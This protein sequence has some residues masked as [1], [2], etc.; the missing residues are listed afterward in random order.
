MPENP[1]LAA[2][3]AQRYGPWALIAGG[4][5]GVG[6]SFARMLA[7]AGI[8]LVLLARRQSPLETL[9]H[10]I[11]EAT[12][13]EVR[14][15]AI[16]LTGPELMSEVASITA[17]IEIGLLIYNAGS[18][19]DYNR[20]PDWKREDLDFMISLNCSSPV[21]LIHQF[22]PPMCER[23]RGGIILLSSMAAFAGSSW[24]SIYSATKAFDQMLAEGLW[25]DLKPCGVDA[26]CLMLGA[27]MTPSHGDVDFSKLNP[28]LPNGGALECDDAAYEGLEYLGKGP[29]WV[30][31]AHNRQRLPADF[32][33]TRRLAIE[34]T[35]AGAAL[36]GRKDHIPAD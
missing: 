25:H 7:G 8:N 24:I 6:E 19:I 21:H 22:A 14:T 3:F 30:P 10:S 34:S 20:F 23:G 32:F 15:L 35:S 36:L 9:A 13:V 33:D 12:A 4:S 17:D 2:G 11:R 27:T 18:T 29:I 1:E 16:D 26:L 31:G 28:D 5:E